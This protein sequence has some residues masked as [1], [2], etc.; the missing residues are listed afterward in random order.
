MSSFIKKLNKLHIFISA[1]F[2][3]IFLITVLLQVV[4]RLLGIAIL[5]TQDVAMYSFIWSVFMG[6]TAM[7]YPERH[8]AF[9]SLVDKLNNEKYKRIIHLIIVLFMLVFLALMFYYGTIVTKR[10][11]NYKWVNLPSMKRGWTW[12]CLPVSSTL[13]CIYLIEKVI[14]DVKALILGG[15]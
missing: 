12:L 1:I 15:K 9:T 11:W 13:G 5:W 14:I 6:G 10:F 2:L 8:F 4:S 3:A 7:V